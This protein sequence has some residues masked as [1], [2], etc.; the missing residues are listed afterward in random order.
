VVKRIEA[1]RKKGVSI[2]GIA[3]ALNE[4]GVPTPHGGQD[5]DEPGV[6]TVD[7]PGGAEDDRLERISW[8]EWFRKLEENGL[9]FV[10][11]EQKASGEDS[12]FFKLV[13]R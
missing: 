3:Q 2:R 8:E 9:A 10:Y 7:F 4:A 12:T 6:L 13:H 11:Q 5:G 1:M